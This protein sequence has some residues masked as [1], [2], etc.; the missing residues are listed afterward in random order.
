MRIRNCLAIQVHIKR[1]ADFDIDELLAI[2]NE[3]GADV[4]VQEGLPDEAYINFNCWAGT[5]V[6]RCAPC[7]SRRLYCLLHRRKWLGR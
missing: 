6:F 1:I 3:T 5:A 4:Q 2:L 7:R